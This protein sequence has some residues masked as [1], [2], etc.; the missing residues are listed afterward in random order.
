M[1]LCQDQAF[2]KVGEYV[3]SRDRIQE[4]HRQAEER[5]KPKHDQKR[6]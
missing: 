6:S 5:A 4:S 2:V 3:E 1:V